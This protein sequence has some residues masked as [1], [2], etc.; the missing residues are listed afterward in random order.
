M[1]LLALASLVQE[2]LPAAVA[3]SRGGPDGEE[4]HFID[5]YVDSYL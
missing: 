5:I 2:M 3:L 4:V 1:A